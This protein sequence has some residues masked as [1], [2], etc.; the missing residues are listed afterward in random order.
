MKNILAI[1]AVSVILSGCVAYAT[2][3]GTGVAVE[4]PEIVVGYYDPLYGYWTGYGWD[5]EYYLFGHPGY[6][7]PHYYGPRYGHRHR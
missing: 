1:A 5:R 4:T 3:N 2:P 6:G 7:H